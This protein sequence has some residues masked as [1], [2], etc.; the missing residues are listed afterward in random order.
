MT[1]AGTPIYRMSGVYTY[2]LLSAVKST[3]AVPF[4]IPPWI[5]LE[6]N[7]YTQIIPSDY[8]QGIINND[9]QGNNTIIN[10]NP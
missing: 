4:D 6:P 2:S 7:E 8:E 1:D 5:T 10:P 9:Y 3:D